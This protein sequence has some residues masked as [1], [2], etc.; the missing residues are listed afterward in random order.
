MCAAVAALGVKLTPDEIGNMLIGRAGLF[1]AGAA[2]QHGV[3]TFTE[4]CSWWRDLVTASP[5]ALIHTQDE[6]DTLMD[7]ERASGRLVV[8]EVGFTF[9]APCKSFK[10]KFLAAATRF[11]EVRFALMTGNE[12]SDT[13]HLGRRGVTPP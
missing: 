2:G 4:F 7:E 10:P 9:C 5:I 6:Y 3:I 1:S 11:S 12:N 8:L 13:V